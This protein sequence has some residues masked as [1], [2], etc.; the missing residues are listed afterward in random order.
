MRMSPGCLL[1]SDSPIS[2]LAQRDPLKIV[3]GGTFC[4]LGRCRRR[5]ATS[6][7]DVAARVVALHSDVPSLVVGRLGLGR[8][9]LSRDGV[10]SLMK[11][12]GSHRV[13]ATESALAGRRGI[14]GVLPFCLRHGRFPLCHRRH[15]QPRLSDRDGRGGLDRRRDVQ[16]SKT[17]VLLAPSEVDEAMNVVVDY[18][19]PGS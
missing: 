7:D 9:P 4:R 16:A 11:V 15:A 12:G 2:G 13:N 18:T 17:V 14:P 8:P 6:A 3:K 10:K 19:P 5:G 1:R